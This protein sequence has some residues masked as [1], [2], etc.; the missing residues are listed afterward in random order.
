M[1]LWKELNIFVDLNS[2]CC[3][4]GNES[5]KPKEKKRRELRK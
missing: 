4:F 3:C 1:R 5:T 2:C